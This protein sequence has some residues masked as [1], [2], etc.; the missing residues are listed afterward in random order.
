MAAIGCPRQPQSRP[1]STTSSAYAE[2]L[3]R[4]GVLVFGYAQTE[5]V[6]EPGRML[7][8]KRDVELD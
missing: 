1:A 6:P 4:S 7:W 2:H 8:I 3:S 5:R